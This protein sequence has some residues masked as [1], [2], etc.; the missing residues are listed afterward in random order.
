MLS[1]RRLLVLLGGLIGVAFMPISNGQVTSRDVRQ[2]AIKQSHV[3]PAAI[4]TTELADLAATVD[5]VDDPTFVFVAESEPFFNAALT[6]T[7]QELASLDVTIPSWVGLIHVF[8]IANA[9][10]NNSSGGNQGLLVSCRVNDEDDGS[11]RQDVVTGT[12]GT[13]DHV[14]AV[15]IST[16]GSTVQISTYVSLTTGTNSG[17]NGAVWAIVLGER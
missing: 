10:M 8:G 6:T 15:S 14:E 17:N 13:V 16:P 1:R 5:K 2:N 4:D 9:L 11:R 12:V 3:F 7:F